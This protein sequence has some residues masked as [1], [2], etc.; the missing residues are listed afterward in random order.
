MRGRAICIMSPEREIH[1]ELA[2]AVPFLD[3]PVGM[4]LAAGACM[5]DALAV[6]GAGADDAFEFG[7]WGRKASP[8]TPLRNGDRI[9]FYRPLIADPKTARRA[10]AKR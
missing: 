8:A 7:I 2:G 3:G 4:R 6:L 1:V 5:A 9:E 10:R